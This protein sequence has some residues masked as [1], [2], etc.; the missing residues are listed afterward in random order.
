MDF[1]ADISLLFNDYSAMFY[2]SGFVKV[3]NRS[4][5]HVEPICFLALGGVVSEWLAA[6]VRW[7]GCSIEVEGSDKRIT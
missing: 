1:L 3:R 4:N 5:V 2:L 6:S 7:V